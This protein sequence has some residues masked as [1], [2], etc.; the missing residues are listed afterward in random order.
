[1][2]RSFEETHR[3]ARSVADE[4]LAAIGIGLLIGLCFLAL[5]LA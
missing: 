2:E 5:G 4:I 3:T 1:M